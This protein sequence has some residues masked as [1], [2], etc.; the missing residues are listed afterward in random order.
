MKR[1][2]FILSI[3]IIFIIYYSYTIGYEQ[4]TYEAY[5]EFRAERTRVDSVIYNIIDNHRDEM[6]NIRKRNKK[7]MDEI[8]NF[9]KNK[10]TW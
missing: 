3:A 9:N 4:G 8:I 5:K 10:K 7:V 1:A 6:L 2:L